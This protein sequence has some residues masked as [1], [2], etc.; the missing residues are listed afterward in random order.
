MPIHLLNEAAYAGYLAPLPDPGIEAGHIALMRIGTGTRR[1]YVKLYAPDTRGLINEIIGH[2]LAEALG[3]CVP[4]RAAVALIPRDALPAVPPWVPHGQSAVAWCTEDLAA[5]SLKVAYR[6]DPAAPPL[7]P[8]IKEL[9]TADTTRALVA[10]DDWIANVDRN[11]GN[12]LRLAKGRY[13][14]I[15]HGHALTG[16]HW[17]APDLNP[18][19]QYP[20]RLRDMLGDCAAGPAAEAAMGAAARDHGEALSAARTELWH[21]CAL[22]LPDEEQQAAV[23]F[24]AARCTEVAI[25]QRYHLLL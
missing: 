21:W 17:R 11:L 23:D 1:V 25:L 6:L 15:D 7:A 20:N 16:P 3:L 13:C 12:L 5:P 18:A 2:L 8:L 9:C 19:P 22:L 10:F 24:L 4:P 14:V